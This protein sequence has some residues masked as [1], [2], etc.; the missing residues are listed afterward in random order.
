MQMYMGLL[1]T[2]P[3]LT[4]TME[5]N[6]E[7]K[8]NMFATKNKEIRIKMIHHNTTLGFN[9]QELSVYLPSW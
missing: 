3:I 8:W 1:Y 7:T 9:L 2:P 6:F 4:Q 5:L